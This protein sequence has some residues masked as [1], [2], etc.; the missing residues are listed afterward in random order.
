MRS[1]LKSVSASLFA[2]SLVLGILAVAATEARA[3]MFAL[4]E[5]TKDCETCPW[6]CPP[7]AIVTDCAPDQACRGL[8]NHLRV[9]TGCEC[10]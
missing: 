8:Y 9:L 1:L 5:L 3:K 2:L 7:N 6:Y 4:C 10:S